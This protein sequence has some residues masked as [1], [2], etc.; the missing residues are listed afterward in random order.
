MCVGTGAADDPTLFHWTIDTGKPFRGAQ[1]YWD[2]M[3]GGAPLAVLHGGGSEKELLKAVQIA[4]RY[5]ELAE[6]DYPYEKPEHAQLEHNE[7]V[8]ALPNSSVFHFEEKHLKLIRHMSVRHSYAAE[9]GEIWVGVDPKRPYGDFSYFEAE[10]A[11]ILGRPTTR[12]EK[13][14]V[15]LAPEVER[16]MSRLHQD[17]SPAV[18][19]FLRH[20]RVKPGVFKDRGYGAWERL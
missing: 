11:E 5:G 14:Q 7:E 8:E 15:C 3:E 1:V 4:F 20:A 16:E 17:M 18:Q 9:G 12:N 10:M 19:V 2:F 13:N 6:G